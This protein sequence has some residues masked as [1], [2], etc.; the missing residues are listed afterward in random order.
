[1]N[2]GET[3]KSDLNIWINKMNNKRFYYDGCPHCKKTAESNNNCPN[4][5]KF[6]DK[7][8]SHFILGI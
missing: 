8:V 3:I 7:A 6:V 2:S 4:C 5:N 1:M